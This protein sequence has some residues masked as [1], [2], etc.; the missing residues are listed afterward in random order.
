MPRAKKR[1]ASGTHGRTVLRSA[2]VRPG[3]MKAHSWYRIT[4]IARITPDDE[5]DLELDD[6]PVAEAQGDD[7]G[8]GELLDQEVAHLVRG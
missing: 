7:L 5:R 6:E 2:G 3:A 8:T 4:G 1:S